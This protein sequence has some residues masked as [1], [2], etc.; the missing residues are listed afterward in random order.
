MNAFN[1]G[2]DAVWVMLIVWSLVDNYKH[3]QLRSGF[4]ST[5]SYWILQV[6]LFGLLAWIMGSYFVDFL[7]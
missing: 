7:N 4:T 5:T 3:Y 1:V 2:F 6:I